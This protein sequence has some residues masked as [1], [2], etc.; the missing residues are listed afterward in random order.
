MTPKETCLDCYVRL[1]APG[2]DASRHRY[3]G[4]SASCW[5]LFANMHNGGDPPIAQGPLNHFF[6][7]AYCVQ[8][9]GVPGPQ[10]IQSVAVHGLP[11]YCRFELGEELSPERAIWMRQ[12]AT[13]DK[14]GQKH[15]RF[16]WLTPPDQ[17]GCLTIGDIAQRP[18][19][20]DRAEQLQAYIAQVWDVWRADHLDSF[21]R[22]FE[23]FVAE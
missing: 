11:L 17:T 15:R 9:H 23:E 12:W 13:F 8:H 5:N 16:T 10:A 7:D 3:I 14:Q 18:T 6:I 20:E 2:P 1:P 4:G 19:P 21:A 22:W